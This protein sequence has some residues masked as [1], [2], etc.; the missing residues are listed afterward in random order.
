MQTSWEDSKKWY[1]RAVGKEGH[2]YHR[3]VIVP[4]VLRL[5][6]LDQIPSPKVLDLACGQGILARHL[7]K[8]ADYVGVDLSAGLIRAAKTYSKHRFLVADVCRPL[9]LKER[10]FTHAALILALQNLP[11]GQKALETAAHHLQPGGR[12]AIVLNHP[13]FRIPRQSS[14]GED[15]AK[16][17]Q[18]RRIDRYMSSLE[19]PLKTHPG[20]ADSPQTLSFHHPLSTYTQWLRKAGFALT[21]IEEW[22]SD[23]KSEGGKAR[24]E[25]ASRREFPLFLTILAQ[26]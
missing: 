7:P 11:E 22:C 5:L 15:K 26:L 9:P 6:E 2:Y 23:K 19:V 8:Q 16:K 20:K 24:M 21:V 14:W 1:D 12:L 13:C 18:Y 10:D 25:D 4:G 17:V 3:Q